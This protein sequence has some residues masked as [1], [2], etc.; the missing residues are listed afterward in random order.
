MIRNVKVRE[1]LPMEKLPEVMQAIRAAE[2]ELGGNG[3]VLVRYSGT[4]QL[5]RV[6]IEAESESMTKKHVEAIADALQREIGE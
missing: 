1:K 6:M 2:A 4:E 3:R 5:A